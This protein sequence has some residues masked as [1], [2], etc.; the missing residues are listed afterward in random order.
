MGGYLFTAGGYQR[1]RKRWRH[2]LKLGSHKF[3]YFHMTDLYAGR[4]IYD[5]VSIPDRQLLLSHAV[6]AITSHAYGGVAVH[7]DK[8]EFEG[9]APIGWEHV[10][11]SIYSLACQMA[12]QATSVW[13]KRDK[14]CDLRVL[15]V[16][17]RGHKFQHESDAMLR[18]IADNE[19][20]AQYCSYGNHIFEKKEK[21][22]GL[23]AADVLAWSVTKLHVG[24]GYRHSIAPWAPSM[25]K[26]KATDR[27]SCVVLSLTGPVLLQFFD[28]AARSYPSAILADAGPRKRAFR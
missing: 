3:P 10:Y 18:A 24:H 9:T 20:E 7:F 1:F 26:L 13:L 5:G 6:E 12:M 23:Q 14:R 4:G 15:Y 28:N 17:E 27:H 2:A 11:G 25:I 22:Y 19:R 16:F 21:E 8:D